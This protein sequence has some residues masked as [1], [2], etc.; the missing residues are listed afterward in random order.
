MKSIH[1]F[2][3]CK[4]YY[5]KKY[6]IDEIL[7]PLVEELKILTSDRRYPFQVAGGHL[8]LHGSVLAVFADIPASQSL[9]GY[10]EGVGGAHLRQV[11]LLMFIYLFDFR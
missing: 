7:K 3:T 4:V 11:G 8:H 2:A 10:K 6:G 1:L 5:I 9:G